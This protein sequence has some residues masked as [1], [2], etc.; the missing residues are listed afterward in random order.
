MTTPKLH[1]GNVI[2]GVLGALY[3]KEAKVGDLMK[4]L[5]SVEALEEQVVRLSRGQ[6]PAR[7]S[8]PRRD[9]VEVIALKH[10]TNH[11]FDLLEYPEEIRAKVRKKLSNKDANPHV[12]IDLLLAEYA[13]N[14]KEPS[15]ATD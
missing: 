13:R 12:V 3:R 1:D 10:L 8:A 15:N 4:A 14:Y 9:T 11:L 5:A 6:V 7:L 2:R